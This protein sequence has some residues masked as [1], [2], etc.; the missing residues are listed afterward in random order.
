MIGMQIGSLMIPY[1]GLFIV[2]GILAGGIAGYIQAKVYYLDINDFITLAG[3]VGIGAMVGAKLL[4]LTVSF[5]Q[6]DFSRVTEPD[7]FTRLMSGGYIFYGGL[8]GG[9][10]GALVCSRMFKF[11][12][13]TYMK[14]EVPLIPLVHAFG[15]IGCLLT[16]C[17][18]GIPYDGPGAIVY[19]NSHIAPIGVSLFPVQGVEAFLEICLSLI[20]FLYI[21]VHDKKHIKSVE[22]Y[23]VTYAVIRFILE[24]LRYDDFERKII[25]GLSV[26]QWVSIFL[27]LGVVICQC[28]QIR[29]KVHKK[30]MQPASAGTPENK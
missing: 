15:R 6:I 24:F 27:V 18:Y 13:M 30:T 19:N 23:L 4:Y 28:R 9:L 7:Y 14:I 16:G 21:Y 20:L 10:L 11:D 25:D 29:L 1:Y 22:I 17:C 26:S 8:L 5:P 12:V 2:L 3:C